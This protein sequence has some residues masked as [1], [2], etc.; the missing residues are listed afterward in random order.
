[1]VEAPI[2]HQV[3]NGQKCSNVAVYAFEHKVLIDSCGDLNRP[4]AAVLHSV[5]NRL[6]LRFIVVSYGVVILLRQ[7]DL[8]LWAVL[9]SILNVLLS[10]TLKHLIKQERPDP[11][12]CSGPGMPSTHAQSISFAVTFII[13]SINEWLGLNGSAVL[14]SGLVIAVGAYF[15]W[16]RVL[17]RYHTTCQVVA[18]IVVGSCFSVLWFCTCDEMVLKAYNSLCLWV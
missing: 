7:D 2:E 13:L 9:G 6:S 8:A 1:M 3:V 14:L 16:L 4:T 10:F 15:I 17:L 5:F 18:G 12:V 11:Q